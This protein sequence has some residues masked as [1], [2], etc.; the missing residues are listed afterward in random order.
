MQRDLARKMVCLTGPRQAGK[1]TLAEMIA[2]QFADA[3]LFNWDVLADRRVMLAQSWVP[4]ASLLVFDELHKMKDWRP[5]LKGVYDG[6]AEGQAILVTGSARLDAF[7]QA[8]ESLAGRYFSWHLLPVTVHELVA[9][10]DT[11]PEEALSRLLIRGGF[12]EPLLAEADADARRWRQLYLDGLIRDDILEFSRIAEVQ[13]MRLFVQMLRER[14]GSPVSLASMARDL[15]L[16]PTTL[17][18]YLGI[19]ETLHVVFIVRPF[20]RNIARAL[21]KEPKVYFYDTGLVKGDDGIRFENAC[22][23]MLQAEVQ[24][25]RDAEGQEATLNYI[26]DK[27]GREIDFVVC[28]ADQPTQ[29]VEC[30]WSDAAVPRYLAATAARFPQARAT[31]LVR[32]LRHREQRG[33]VAV[34]PAAPWL[35]DLGAG[36]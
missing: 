13:A 12:P 28:D 14:V 29:L 9:T 31:L 35:A 5:W 21:L 16:S 22:A 1:T 33:A 27:E 6:R 26:R 23:T 25:R 8:G 3:R 19:L 7:R 24:R 10:T 4:T 18:R 36:H 32:H 30:K 17:S 2:G 20:H 11:A 15:Q 34:E